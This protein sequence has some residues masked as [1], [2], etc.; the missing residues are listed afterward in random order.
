MSAAGVAGR[1]R[2]RSGGQ[3]G[4]RAQQVTGGEVGLPG[5][6]GD[7]EVEHLHLA[8][9]GQEDVARLDVA[10][11][12]PRAVGRLERVGDRRHDPGR[13]ARRHRA[14]AVDPSG[15]AL[16][17]QQLHDQ[18][19]PPVVL[20][21]VKHPGDVGVVEPGRRPRLPAQPLGGPAV[22]GQ[23]PPRTLTA[24]G[25]SSS[26]SRATHTSPIPPAA[27]GAP[28]RYRPPRWRPSTA[29]GRSVITGPGPRFPR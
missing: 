4:G 10:V 8:L 3:V 16:A 17:L 15:Q 28:I 1:P 21:K 29:P 27:S 6:R 25:R 23:R 13:L 9:G 20:A 24:T 14:G 11:D 19:R 18:V 2:A 5:R 7:P 26:G 22:A 12:D